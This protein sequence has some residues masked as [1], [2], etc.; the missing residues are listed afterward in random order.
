MLVVT[1]NNVGAVVVVCKI[2]DYNMQIYL[3]FDSNNSLSMQQEPF[4]RI[5]F[6]IFGSFA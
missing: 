2:V 4:G 5:T 1:D 6:D 3:N